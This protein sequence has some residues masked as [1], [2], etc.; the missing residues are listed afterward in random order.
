MPCNKCKHFEPV[1]RIE[2]GSSI[3]G[4]LCK[5]HPPIP[6]ISPRGVGYTFVP[7]PATEECGEFTPQSGQDGRQDSAQDGS[8]DPRIAMASA[9]LHT[10]VGAR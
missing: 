9:V 10:E 5:A 3:D 8:Q 6:L 2:S 4:G 7:V 1:G